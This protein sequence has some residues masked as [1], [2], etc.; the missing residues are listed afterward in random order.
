[1]MKQVWQLAWFE[2]RHISVFSIIMFIIL[3]PVLGFGASFVL[4]EGLP[5]GFDLIFFTYYR[6][7]FSNHDL[8]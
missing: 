6:F 7:L 3:V 1:M 4:R 5:L 2:M 8:I